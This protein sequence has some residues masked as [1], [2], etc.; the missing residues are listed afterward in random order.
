MNAEQLKTLEGVNK[1]IQEVIDSE[2]THIDYQENTTPIIED[3]T[4]W[5]ARYESERI[6]HIKTYKELVSTVKAIKVLFKRYREKGDLWN[7]EAWEIIDK[8]IERLSYIKEET[9]DEQIEAFGNFKHTDERKFLD[10]IRKKSRYIKNNSIN[11]DCIE[12]S[13]K[14]GNVFL[15]QDDFK[16]DLS[17]LVDRKE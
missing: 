14:N 10:E 9:L 6:S 16:A 3:A 7:E 13:L 5:K 15:F 12:V 11:L 8:N 17:K 4:M 1:F 2:K